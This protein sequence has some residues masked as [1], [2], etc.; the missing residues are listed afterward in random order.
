MTP[1]A[2][3]EQKLA[4]HIARQTLAKFFD[5]R[6]YIPETNGQ[7]VFSEPRGVFV[8]LWKTK[9]LRGCIGTF[10]T[11]K[12]LAQNIHD[13]ALAAAFDDMRFAPLA[14]YELQ[15]IKIEISALSL[16]QKI[17]SID[18]ITLGRHGVFIKNGKKSGVFLPQVAQNTGWTKEQFLDT[19]CKE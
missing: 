1:L 5:K 3:S 4:L 19:L 7:E 10:E 15:N 2:P 8:T 13:M 11:R 9:K 16:M 12:P 6:D 17:T 14:K 18:E